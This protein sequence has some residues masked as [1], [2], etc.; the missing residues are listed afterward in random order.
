M[1]VVGVA[2]ISHMQLLLSLYSLKLLLNYIQCID[3]HRFAEE[4]SY[5]TLMVLIMDDTTNSMY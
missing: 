5:R 4:F 1:N 3:N 2:A